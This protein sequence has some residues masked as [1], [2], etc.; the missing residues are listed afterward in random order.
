VCGRTNDA[1]RAR[2]Y[3]DLDDVMPNALIAYPRA[4]ST[5]PG[6]FAWSDP[7]DPIDAQR[8]F[9]FVAAL[10]DA[11]GMAHCVD[12]NRVFVVGHSLGAYFANDLACHTTGI[13]RAVASVAGGLRGE[14]CAGPTAA[15]LVHHP[16]DRLVPISEGERARDAFLAATGLA[17]TNATSAALPPLAALHCERA[18]DTG[19]ANPV[20]WCP[21]DGTTSSGRF[22]PHGWPDGTAAAIAAF[23]HDLP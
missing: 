9:A 18:G 12:L 8:D 22:D 16:N 14:T 1:A 4:L 11:V 20:V 17:L 23:F 2:A 7:G 5:G 3:F 19:A 15:L 21:H 10:V 6:T 13:V